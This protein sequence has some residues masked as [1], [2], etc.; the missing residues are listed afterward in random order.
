MEEGQLQRTYDFI[1]VGAGSAGC[2]I[3]ARLSEN[4]KVTILLIEA[5]PDSRSWKIDMPLA[6]DQLLT[7]T[8]Y[9]WGFE[10]VAEPGLGGRKIAQ[11][12]GRAVGGSSAINGMVYTRGNPQDYDAWRDEYGCA[13]WGYADVL[14]YFKRMETAP[15][16]RTRYRGGEGPMRVSYPSPQSNPLN[17]AFLSAARER[18]YPMSE[19]GNGAQHEGFS[20]SEMSIRDGRRLSTARAYLTGAV[21]R[22]SNL[23]IEAGLLTERILIKDRQ[24]AGVVASRGGAR[25]DIR[26]RREVVLAAGAVGS[27]HLLMLS[28][29]GPAAELVRHGI[30]VVLDQPAVGANLQD[31]PDLAIQYACTQPVTLLRHARGLGRIRTGLAWFLAKSGV[32]ATNQFEAAGYF[33]TRAGIK[34]PNM[35]LEFFPLAVSPIDYRPYAEDAFQIHMTLQNARSRGAIRLQG[36]DVRTPPELVLNYLSDALDMQTFREAVALT[37]EIVAAPAFDAFRGREIDPGADVQG[38]ADLDAWIRSRVTTAYHLSCT[39]R[40]GKASDPAAVVG[41]DLRVHGLDGLR[42]ADASVMPEIV[43]A[44][45]NATTIMIGE[46]AADFLRGL[47]QLAPDNAPYWVHPAWETSQR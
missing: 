10:T 20:A 1:V 6:V 3:A 25:H 22:R 13:G 33:R 30:P 44:N 16:E 17:Q 43:T 40:M 14:G 7:S 37:R 42:I 45:L 41:P 47:P 18:G 46:R 12:R 24:A 27:P 21:R 23:T 26:A 28:G 39:C 11:P 5:G 34:K 4:P 9:N 2:A 32:A 15:G 35:K 29:I 8:T 19:D 31:H 38:E 36:P